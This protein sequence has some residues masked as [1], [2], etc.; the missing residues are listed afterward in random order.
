MIGDEWLSWAIQCQT[1]FGMKRLG[2][3]I[4]SRVDGYETL[5]HFFSRTLG[6]TLPLCQ[7]ASPSRS[8]SVKAMINSRRFSDFSSSSTSAFWDDNDAISFVPKNSSSP[9]VSSSWLYRSVR[10]MSGVHA[11]AFSV[12]ICELEELRVECASQDVPKM[13]LG[14]S[15]LPSGELRMKPLAPSL[16]H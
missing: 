10:K 4:L 1:F 8:K 6:A 7:S 2:T 11:S 12:S 16:L 15:S 5:R 3:N 9:I 14:L 13:W